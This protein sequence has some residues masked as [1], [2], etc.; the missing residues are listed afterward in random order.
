M[1]SNIYYINIR[2]GREAFVAGWLGRG[3]NHDRYP[4]M[5]VLG[6][7]SPKTGEVERGSRITGGGR[8]CA[9]LSG[10]GSS[11]TF[12]EIMKEVTDGGQTKL[13]DSFYWKQPHIF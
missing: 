9:M 13:E 4:F 10:G 6:G 7:R 8:P 12:Q 5:A 3:Y 11:N 1:N 2:P